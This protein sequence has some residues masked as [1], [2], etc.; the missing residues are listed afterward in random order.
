MRV[1]VCVCVGVGWCECVVVMMRWMDGSEDEI[2]GTS[3]CERREAG[4]K[5]RRGLKGGACNAASIMKKAGINS[6]VC[7]C[8]MCVSGQKVL[9]RSSGRQHAF[10]M[11]RR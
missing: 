5:G 9:V 2:E 10:M 7:V 6:N 3:F 8:V 11:K 4:R 1:C